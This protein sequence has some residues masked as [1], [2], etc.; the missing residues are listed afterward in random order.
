MIAEQ[1]APAA[2]LPVAMGDDELEGTLAFDAADELPD[3]AP[4]LSPV[5][6]ENSEA[7]AGAPVFVPFGAEELEAIDEIVQAIP[8]AQ[9]TVDTAAMPECACRCAARLHAA[10]RSRGAPEA[11]GGADLR[12]VG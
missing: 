12:R 4:A 7:S 8:A 1:D 3:E 6:A 5:H 2:A 11:A 10:Q 9:I